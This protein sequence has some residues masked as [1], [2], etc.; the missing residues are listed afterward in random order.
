MTAL[1]SCATY[2]GY[3]EL[4]LSRKKLS[5]AI[6][7]ALLNKVYGSIHFLVVQFSTL[8]LIEPEPPKIEPENTISI[9]VGLQDTSPA[10][11][12]Q[13]L[14]EGMTGE[15][16]PAALRDDVHQVLKDEGWV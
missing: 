6:N 12:S 10:H 11:L 8:T 14:L 1:F 7:A 4:V 2:R 16:V 9:L 15:Q 13:A 3:D 5:A